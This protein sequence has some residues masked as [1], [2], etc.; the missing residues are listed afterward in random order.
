[1]SDRKRIL[2]VDDEPDILTVVVFRLK[3]AGYDVLTAIDGEQG[4]EMA[5]RERPSLILLDLQLPGIMG[6]EVCRRLKADESLKEIPVILLS[7]STTQIKEEARNM[8]VDDYLSKPYEPQEL[9]AK[10][11]KYID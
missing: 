6:D 8:G 3:K 1:M 5:G 9:L 2:I 4:L 10:V 7:A 11:K